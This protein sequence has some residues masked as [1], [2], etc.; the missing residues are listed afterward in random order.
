[1]AATLH[2]SRRKAAEI[3]TTDYEALRLRHLVDMRSRIPALVERFDWPPERLKA[4]REAR[5][6]KLVTHA[7]AHSAWHRER[8]PDVDAQTLTEETLRDVPPM[9]KADLMDHFDAISTDPR[10]TRDASETHLRALESDAYLFD[11][12]HVCA[13]GGSTGRR[14]LCAWDWEAWSGGWAMF[15]AHLVRLRTRDPG[16]APTRSP[17][18]G[19]GI[20]AQDPMHMS[21]ALQ[22]CFSDP[23]MMLMHSVP[24]T[25]PFEQILSRVNALQPDIVTGYPSALHRLAAAQ[26]DGRSSIA[27]KLV[28]SVSEPLLPEIRTAIDAAW[29]TRI[30]NF[31]AT[32]EGMTMAMSCGFGPG[33]HLNDDQLIIEPVDAAGKP[34]PPGVRAAKIYV[35]NLINVD[36]LPLIRY[37]ITDEVTLLEDQCP[38]GSTR[39]L[40][41]DIQGRLDDSFS[42]SDVGVV[43][44]HVFRS[45]L[46]RERHVVEYQVVQTPRGATIEL[47]CNGR[48]DLESV[49]QGLIGDLQRLGLTDPQVGI[50]SVDAIKRVVSG[51]LRRFVP[52]G[53]L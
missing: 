26:H 52:L 53:K 51:K 18:L 49:R 28:I 7:K 47:C 19:A 10:V 11:R 46:G 1:M 5:L 37:E 29:D 50:L 23:E 20:C 34:V 32:T 12:Y 16:A 24:V 45:R 41:D 27:P 22:C 21:S 25:L 39:R 36:P 6:R 2:Q 9:S 14:G 40:V 30:L 43:H 33:M 13:S 44:P 15:V 17:M 38:C 35:T 3:Q 48:V 31:W 4:D 42:Y 8:L